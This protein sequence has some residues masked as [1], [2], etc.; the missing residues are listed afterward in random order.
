MEDGIEA[1]AIGA[2]HHAIGLIANLTTG[3]V[4]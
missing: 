2:V 3:G 1:L 4:Q